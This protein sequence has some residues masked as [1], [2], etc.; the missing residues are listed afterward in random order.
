MSGE[1]LIQ[2]LRM[3]AHAAVQSIA[4]RCHT[5]GYYQ[6]GESVTRLLTLI[7]ALLAVAQV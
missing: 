1:V 6:K 2:T 7:D 3:S 4:T 5:D